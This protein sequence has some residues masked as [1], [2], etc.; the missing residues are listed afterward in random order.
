[1]ATAQA[2]ALVVS[3]DFEIHWGV[4]ERPSTGAYRAHLLGVPESVRGT[5]ALFREFEVRAT[6]A[7]VGMLFAR[8][9]AERER[10]SPAVRPRYAVP[11]PDPYA[12]Q[13][14]DGEADDPLHYAPT[15][16]DEIA[17][18]PGQELATHTFAHLY[19]LEP[20]ENTREAFRADLR[21]ARAIMRHAAGVEPRSIVFPRNQ[22]DPALN[23]VLVDEGVT[24][25]R[26]NGPSWIWK[27]A[28]GRHGPVRRAARLLDSYAGPTR[29]ARWAEVAQPDG[30]FNVPASFFVRP[31]A[32]RLGARRIAAAMAAAARRGEIVH[33]W[34]HPHNFGVRTPRCLALLRGLLETFAALRRRQGLESLGMADVA[35]RC[36]SPR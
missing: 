34:W 13:T 7:T 3:L 12:V 9:R 1:M 14:G 32:G 24:C 21:A 16:I 17:A 19:P 25:F 22:H 8:S 2:G 5:L 36:G 20:G 18:T 29:L 30:T 28:P 33:L 6:W 27:A 15:L 35:A 26:G 23:D 4:L 10:F 31:N 11:L